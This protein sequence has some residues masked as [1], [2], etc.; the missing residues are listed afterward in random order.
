V[1]DASTDASKHI[2]LDLQKSYPHLRIITH[3]RRSGQSA[4]ILSGVKSARY[5]WIA[6]LDGDGQ[7]DPRDIL[8][9]IEAV[10]M[11]PANQS[12]DDGAASTKM[13]PADNPRDDGAGVSATKSLGVNAKILCMGFRVNRKDSRARKISSKIA[14]KIRSRLLKDQ[15]PDSACGIKLFPRELF[16][17]LPHFRN[18]HR[19]LPALFIRA[20]AKVINVPVNHRP[21]LHGSSKY[22]LINRLGTGILD[23]LGVAWLMRRKIDT[24]SLEH[25]R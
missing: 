3:A 23:L 16:L 5:E 22:G 20:G 7:N 6:T 15:S 25:E 10:K 11:D 12:R 13:D 19:F 2:L 1:N 18:D 9:F 21:R 8:K 24:E 4:A 17:Q 14:N